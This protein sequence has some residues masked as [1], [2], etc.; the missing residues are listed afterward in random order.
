MTTVDRTRSEGPS[1][2]LLEFA[3]RFNAGEFERCPEALLSVWRPRGANTFHK[4]LIQLAGAY[5]HWMSGNAFWA[6][7]LFASSYNLLQEYAP[8]HA[9]LDVARL[10]EGIAACNAV[11]RQVKESGAPPPD[12][13]PMPRLQL[14]LVGERPQAGG[15]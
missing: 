9:G 15:P 5:Q 1:E 7:D 6:E 13:D 8:V 2:E 3:R 4:G 14:H 12:P 11:A 10:L